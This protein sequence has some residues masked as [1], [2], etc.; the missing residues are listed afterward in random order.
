LIMKLDELPFPALDKVP[1]EKYNVPIKQSKPISNIITSRGCPMECTFCFHTSIWR[2]RSAENVVDEIE[3]QV[4]KLGV[5]EIAVND[6]NFT[7]DQKRAEKICDIIIERRIKVKL[8]SMNGIRADRVDE[9]LLRKMRKAGFWMV[10]VAPESGSEDTLEQVKKNLDLEQVVQVVKWC[11]ELRLATYSFFMI[12]FP[13]ENR[14]DILKTIGFS[15]KLDTDFVQFSRVFPIEGTEFYGKIKKNNILPEQPVID[16]GFF[17]GSTKHDALTKISN[18][19]VSNLIK[20][21]Y[22]N[23]YLRPKKMLRIL[24][25]LQIQDIYKLARYALITDSM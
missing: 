7:L 1:I 12:G 22:R 8:Q 16:D 17:F 5:K 10:A 23:S 20:K 18:E 24:R 9:K 19:E 2:P 13:W 11:K 21:A 15:R 25:L 14:E 6:D 4:K 3:W